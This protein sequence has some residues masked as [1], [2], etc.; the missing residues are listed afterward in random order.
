MD[1][2]VIPPN[3]DAVSARVLSGGERLAAAGGRVQ[4]AVVHGLQRR[5]YLVGCNGTPV[6][7][8]VDLRHSRIPHPRKYIRVKRIVHGLAGHQDDVK[9]SQLR[10]GGRVVIT[11]G[12]DM[13]VEL[14]VVLEPTPSPPNLFHW[15]TDRM[16]SG[17]NCGLR[18]ALNAI[19]PHKPSRI[20][21]WYLL[22]LLRW[23]K[24]FR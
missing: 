2:P 21:L 10:Q 8:T 16:R 24:P 17:I 6:I 9:F 22:V 14:Q 3:H 12:E 19:T 7:F 15:L 23:G 5:K 13:E 11:L 20:R 4:V 18:R 1:F